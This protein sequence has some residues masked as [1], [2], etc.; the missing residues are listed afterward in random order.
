MAE[1]GL[2]ADIDVDYR[3]SKSPQSWF[4]GHLTSSNS[5][6]RAGDNAQR[7]TRRWNGFTN[8]WS[9]TFGSVRFGAQ[10]EE[11][12]GPFGGAPT[13][14]PSAVPPNRPA[15]A[16]IPEIADAVQEFLTDWL[17]RRN[18]QEASAFLAPDVLPCVADSMD[19]NPSTSPE[20]LRQASLKLLER[21]ANQWGRPTSL[22]QA[23]YPVVP[24][25]PAVRVVKHAF[26]QDFTIV[27]APTE[28][29]AQ[30][31]CG[32]TP[33]K[34]FV[35]S[36]TPEFGEVLRRPA[37]GHPRRTPGRDDRARLAPGEQ[38]LAAGFLS[39]GGIAHP[40]MQSLNR[41]SQIRNDWRPPIER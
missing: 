5:D 13:R 27:E 6:V 32:A 20:R 26:E 38:R 2:S 7:H 11:A 12:A 19:M 15:N 25:S 14:V 1:D 28:L 8:W 23:M 4:N 37:A 35:P 21:A 18:Y 24:W 41:R 34:K 10:D 31:E 30:Y 33:P 40:S 29:G 3:T 36:A 17:I 9:D 39:I 22:T 16:S